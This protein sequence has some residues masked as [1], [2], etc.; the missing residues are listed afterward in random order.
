MMNVFYTA[1]ASTNFSNQQIGPF[2]DLIDRRVA[3]N[4]WKRNEIKITICANKME[5]RRIWI[6]S[7]D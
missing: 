6:K 3:R 5:R 2:V 4:E 1:G 7:H